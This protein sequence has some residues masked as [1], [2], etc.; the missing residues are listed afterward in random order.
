[1]RFP[2]AR[3]AARSYI[4]MGFR[5]V[6]LYGVGPTGCNCGAFDCK[7][8]D[9]G[10][11]A[12]E[13]YEDAWKAGANYEPNDFEEGDNIGLIMGPWRN[14]LWTVALDLDGTETVSEFIAGLP[15]T[16]AQRTPRGMHLVYTVPEFT[17]LG[18]YVDVFKTKDAGYSLDL[19]YARGRIVAA[20]SRGATGDYAWTD[21]R[22]PA[23]LPERAIDAILDERRANGLPVASRWERG[24]KDP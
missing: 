11:H 24:R 1:M 19:R 2:S 22:E 7:D 3:A 18:N 13:G 17:P 12:R 20:P 15:L 9:W 16:M 6:P 4:E 23:P 5:V 14:R 8:R 10:K 21:F